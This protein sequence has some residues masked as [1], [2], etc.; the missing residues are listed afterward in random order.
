A[1]PAAPG[2]EPPAAQR[3]HEPVVAERD[4]DGRAE[5]G[6]GAGRPQH[7]ALRPPSPAPSE[8]A[9][10]AV[11]RMSDHRLRLM[12]AVSMGAFVIV[13]G[14][15]VQIQ[16]VDAASLSQKAVSQQRGE[17]TLP[18]LRGSIMSADGQ[19]LAQTQPSKTIVSSPKQVK[20]VSL[21]AAVIA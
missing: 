6:H 19:V 13:I 15:A 11:R 17:T 1:P 5:A 4:R 21:A 14:R 7:D 12:L 3:G 8:G 20:N 18:G 10:P 9:D 2:R 16:G